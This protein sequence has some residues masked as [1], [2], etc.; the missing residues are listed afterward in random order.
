MRAGL[1][2]VLVLGL[3]CLPAVGRGGEWPQFRGP[4]G[5]GLATE[6]QLPSAW[7]DQNVQWK[8]RIPGTGWSSPII[9]GD[10]VFVTTA[11]T[12]NQAK[13]RPDGGAGGGG[14][15]TGGGAGR[16]TPSPSAGFRWE[17]HCLDRA[18]GKEIWKQL[19]SEGKPRIPTHA[20][21]TYASETPVTDGERVYVY[22]GMTGLFC[23]DIKGNLVWKKDLGAYPMQTGWGTGSSPVLDG[24]R[25]FLQ[26]DNEQNSFLVALDKRTG[27]ELWR[28]PRHEKSSWST[29]YLWKTQQRTELVTSATQRVR[30]YDPATGKVFWELDIGGGRCIAAPVAAD[31][32][33]YVGSEAFGGGGSFFAVRAGA[34]GDISLKGGATA[35][36]GV[37]WLQPKSGLGMASPLVYRGHVYILERRGGLVSCYDAKTGKPAY[38]KERL[39][40][41][42]GFWASPWGYDGKIFCLDDDGQTFVLQ[43]GPEFKLVGKNVLPDRFWATP[44]AAGEA[45]YLRGVDYVYCIKQ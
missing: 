12:E 15:K 36:A 32:L 37:A 8:V 14:G 43:S 10:Q 33:L 27:T 24:N 42:K 22:F 41:A 18:T 4:G 34:S 16:G 21:N 7:G 20:S 31:E 1:R 11:V 3:V 23:Y 19:A 6:K 2:L 29:P 40:S 26:C 30:S 38:A 9:W 13:P 28:V 5:T 45:L 44:A 17:V 35:N 25:L 39:P